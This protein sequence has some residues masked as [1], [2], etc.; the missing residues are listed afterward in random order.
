MKDIDVFSNT[1]YELNDLDFSSKVKAHN[2][3]KILIGQVT[4]IPF[5]S[6][7]HSYDRIYIF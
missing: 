4:K 1:I 3:A 5:C 7:D 6:N 2:S